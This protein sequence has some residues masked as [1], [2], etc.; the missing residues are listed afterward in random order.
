M[1]ADEI[2]E[3]RR[4]LFNQGGIELCEVVPYRVSKRVGR[5]M[6]IDETDLEAWNRAAR[7]NWLAALSLTAK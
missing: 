5:M 7:Y 3:E 2:G 6:P 4:R 1:T